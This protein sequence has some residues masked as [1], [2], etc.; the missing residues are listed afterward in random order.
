[1]VYL[2]FCI[3]IYDYNVFVEIKLEMGSTLYSVET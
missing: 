2:I 1:M 3:S